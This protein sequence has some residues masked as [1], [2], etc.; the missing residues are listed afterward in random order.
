M[1]QIAVV[2]LLAKLALSV[3]GWLRVLTNANLSKFKRSHAS[4]ARAISSVDE[5]KTISQFI[6]LFVKD[7]WLQMLVRRLQTRVEWC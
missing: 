4:P 3:D 7:D 1:A 5:R 2:P 6:G